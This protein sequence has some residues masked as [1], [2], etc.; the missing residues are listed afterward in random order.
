[1]ISYAIIW[2]RLG[3]GTGT[4]TWDGTG[5]EGL[6]FLIF[7][8]SVEG[9]FLISYLRFLIFRV[10]FMHFEYSTCHF[11]RVRFPEKTKSS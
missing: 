5:T 1:M 11:F 2:Y 6:T 3:H 9:L 7:E 10:R 8:A 4:G